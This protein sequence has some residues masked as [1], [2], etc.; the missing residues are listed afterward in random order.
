MAQLKDDAQL[1]KDR[2]LKA[3]AD[4]HP[5]RPNEI[6]ED[7]YRQVRA[8]LAQFTSIYTVNYDLLMYW[9]G[10]KMTYRQ[11]IGAPMTVFVRIVCRLGRI[12]TKGFSFLRRT[13]P[14]RNT[15]RCKEAFLFRYRAADNRYSAG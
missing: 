10:T 15:R 14:V 2:L 9:D 13:A 5:S 6:S 8:F 1:I 3:I 7:E 4:T 11:M 12:R